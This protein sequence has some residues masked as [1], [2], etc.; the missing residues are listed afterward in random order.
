MRLVGF[1]IGSHD[2]NVA[3]SIDGTVTYFK[4]ERSSKIKH[5]KADIAFVRRCWDAVAEGSPDAVAFSDGNRNMLGSCDANQLVSEVP[6]LTALWPSTKTFCMDHHYAHALS[7]WPNIDLKAVDV[8]FA[9][10]GMGD[11]GSRLRVFKHLGTLNPTAIFSSKEYA[12]GR[13]LNF[14]GKLM[15]LPGL[16]LDYGGKLMALQAFGKADPD[17]VE[18]HD[19]ERLDDDIFALLDNILWRGDLPLRQAEFFNP[20]NESFLDW[21][22]SVH[23]LIERRVLRLLSRYAAPNDRIV[24]AGG[25]AQN[26]VING[27]IYAQFNQIVIPPHSYDGGI[28]LGC[29]QFLAM[30]T[31]SQPL[32]LPNFPFC[33]SDEFI[34]PPSRETIRKVAQELSM[35]KTIGLCFGHGE[36]GPRAL[37]HRSI[38]GDPRRADL[39][40]FIN[41]NIKGRES[42]RP[43]APS[44]LEE[45]AFSWFQ[46]GRPSPHMMC[47][48]YCRPEKAQSIP[49]VVHIDGSSRIQTVPK[50]N[51][52][53][54]LGPFRLLIEEFARLTDIP[55]VLNTSLNFNSEPIIG[56]KQAVLEAFPSSNLDGLCL[57]NEFL[58]RHG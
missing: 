12:F 19:S 45:E 57:G 39:K 6:A 47:T 52:E 4:S 40:D 25:F 20:R 8:A 53:D 18:K 34:P 48:D 55:L 44:I 32:L 5:H 35:G 15:R 2:S 46:S 56:S 31:G 14:V 51:F 26:S 54:N 3:I 37:G 29:L 38:V 23:S 9:L 43:F 24:Y 58:L 10:D 7:A 42:W 41:S 36:I 49:A 50:V 30:A 22:A 28:S 16:P 27:S 17:F 1:Y 13:F 11:N 33:Q 21:L